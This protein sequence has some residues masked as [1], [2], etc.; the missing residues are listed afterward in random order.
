METTNLKQSAGKLGMFLV[1]QAQKQIQ[2]MNRN[3]LLEQAEIKKIYI[4]KMARKSTEIR[5]AFIQK[6][7]SHLINSMSDLL[8]ELSNKILTL[9]ELLLNELIDEIRLQSASWISQHSDD[10]YLWLQ[11]SISKVINSVTNEKIEIRLN[12]KDATWYNNNKLV[13]NSNYKIINAKLLGEEVIGGF[14][15]DFPDDNLT[16]DHTID[17]KIEQKK[18]KVEIIL[19]KI[20]SEEKLTIAK[21]DVDNFM[22]EQEIILQQYLNEYDRL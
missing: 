2:E 4:E 15:L 17:Q 3:T 6:Y 20:F 10:Y 13:K 19:S 11:D 22:K 8:M 18:N 21:E 5:K 1:K 14:I 12:P 16:I 7:K 9:K